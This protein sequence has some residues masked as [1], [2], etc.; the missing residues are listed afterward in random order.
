MKKENLLSLK[1]PDIFLLSLFGVGFFPKM[2]GTVGSLCTLP[3]LYALGLFHPPFWIFLPFFIVFTLVSCF[4][5]ESMQKRT[6]TSDPSWVVL[7]EVLGMFAAWVFMRPHTL[8]DLA[9]LFFLFRF[10]DIVKPWPVARIDR[11]KHGAGI[12]LDDVAAGIYAA[13]V[14]FLW[15]LT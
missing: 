3:L 11:I 15:R 13:L 8:L 4:I 6:G 10:F 7:D 2:P 5:A 9:I 1:N 14:F 12:M